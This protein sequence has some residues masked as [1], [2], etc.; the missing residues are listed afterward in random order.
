MT[1]VREFLRNHSDILALSFL[2]AVTLIRSYGV[3]G[4]LPRFTGAV[5]PM[6]ACEDTGFRS[7][8]CPELSPFTMGQMDDARREIREAEMAIRQ[9]R[10]E[11]R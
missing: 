5:I 9:L 8:I 2:I 4:D 10:F 7:P 6:Q 1:Q 3:P 11:L